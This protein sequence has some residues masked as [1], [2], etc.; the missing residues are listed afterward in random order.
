MSECVYVYMYMLLCPKKLCEYCL[1]IFE[2][3]KKF[4]VDVC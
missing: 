2:L 1:Y 4:F 3:Y